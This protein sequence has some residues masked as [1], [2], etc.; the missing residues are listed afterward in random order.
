MLA[1]ASPMGFLAV[2]DFAR[3]RGFYEGVLGLAFVTPR[4]NSR[5]SCGA[6]RL[7]IRFANSARDS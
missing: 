4:T 3:A 2:S 6:G 1:N 5:S 7:V